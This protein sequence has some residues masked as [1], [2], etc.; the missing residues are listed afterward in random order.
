MKFNNNMYINGFMTIVSS[1]GIPQADY[2]KVIAENKDLKKN[3]EKITSELYECHNGAEKTIAKVLKAYSQKEYGTAKE[4]I[5]KLSEKHPESPKNAEFK[6][7]LEIIKKEEFALNKVKEE[8]EKYRIRLANSNNT[9]M[10]SVKYYIDEF[11]E[12]TKDGYIT[13]SSHIKGTFSN[14]E[15]RNSKLNIN[16]FINDPSGISIQLYEYAKNNP[17]K[18][19]SF[20]RYRVLV[21]D[22]D[23]EILKLRAT[24]YSD[25]LRL[26]NSDSRK[27]DKALKKGGSLKFK[28]YRI[29]TPTIEYEFTISNADWY[30]NSQQKLGI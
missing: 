25:R 19:H 15:T 11:G 29:D 4:N 7:L 3:I 24:N 16:F 2:D 20:E 23:K 17:L 22:K 18:A 13:N 26:L 1:C 10:W 5:S 30:G 28:I 9:G 12:P 21:K 14:I 6:K 27:L 8:E